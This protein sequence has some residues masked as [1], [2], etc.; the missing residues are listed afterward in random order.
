MDSFHKT[1][2]RGLIALAWTAALGLATSAAAAALPDTAAGK[3]LQARLQAFA[4]G[5]AEQLAQY[6]ARHEQDLDVERE[7]A[8]YRDTGGFDVL[9]VERSEP[10]AIAAVIR[11]RDSDTIGRVVLTVDTKA[12][13]RV[14]SVRLQPATDVPAEFMPARLGLPSVLE[15]VQDKAT[16]MAARQ[17]FSGNLLIARNGKTLL[18][19]SW[20]YANREAEIANDSETRFRIASMFKMFTAVA[21]LQLVDAGKLDLDGKIAAYLPDYPNRDLATQ[22]TVRQLLTHTGGAG[23]IFTPEYFARREQVREHRDYVALFGHRG[24]DFAPGSASRYSNYGYVLLGAIIEEVTG[25]S[26]YEYLHEQ[27]FVPAGM[28]G[29]GALPEQLVATQL[30][31]GYAIK[32]GRLQDN[33]DSLPWRGTA[34]GGGYSTAGDLVRFVQALQAGRL[35][36]PQRLAQAT[37]AQNDDGWYGFGFLVGGEAELRWFGHDGGADGMSASLRVYPELGYVLVGLANV[38][39]PA[40]ERL[41]EYFGN[42]MPL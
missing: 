18:A 24:P 14:A 33:R 17:Q 41:T 12:P 4:S 42:R 8:F 21:V 38:D 37:H 27:V 31:V 16:A 29:T 11:A 34:A 40:A 23:D 6:S 15:G 30:A 32:D 39:P 35:L 26:Y 19:R 5:S 1:V 28:T 10:Y 20:G 13:E 3:V 22:V 9:K 7:L 36:S 2:R 25:R